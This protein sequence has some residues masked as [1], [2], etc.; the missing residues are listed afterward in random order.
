MKNFNFSPDAATGTTT[1]KQE[2]YE[3][4]M[5]EYAANK[6]RKEQE[7][8]EKMEAQWEKVEAEWDENFLELFS[9]E[10]CFTEYYI[11]MLAGVN[12]L[13]K[14]LIDAYIWE[15]QALFIKKKVDLAKRYMR[16]YQEMLLHEEMQSD[17]CKRAFIRNTELLVY[18][19]MWLDVCSDNKELLGPTGYDTLKAK[20]NKLIMEYLDAMQNNPDVKICLARVIFEWIDRTYGTNTAGIME[21]INNKRAA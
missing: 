11:T 13:T 7:E 4:K 6:A 14:G 1:A 19:I 12:D 21:R 10:E 20:V 2:K 5:A 17:E 15:A 16:V 18:D 8:N 3:K 9:D